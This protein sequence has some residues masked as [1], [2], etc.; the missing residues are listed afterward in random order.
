MIYFIQRGVDGPIK[1]GFTE[2][3]IE[4]RTRSIQTSCPEKLLL[5][6]HV[7]GTIGQENAA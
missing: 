1:I 3:N 5:L 2:S 6:G 4:D 7:N